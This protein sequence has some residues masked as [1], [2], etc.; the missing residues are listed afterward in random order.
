[1]KEPSAPIR[2]G[3][4][5]A[6][7]LWPASFTIGVTEAPGA[8]SI[9]TP[10]AL[11][12]STSPDFTWIAADDGRILIIDPT[13]PATTWVLTDDAGITIDERFDRFAITAQEIPIP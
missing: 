3:T 4:P 1:V 8:A 11:R 7:A 5:A 12:R 10:K 9:T 13:D 6:K 2:T